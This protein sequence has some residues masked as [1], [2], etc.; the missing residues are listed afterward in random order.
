MFIEKN[1]IS[2]DEKLK[3]VVFDEIGEL[4]NYANEYYGEYLLDL[5][6]DFTE[7]MYQEDTLSSMMISHIISWGILC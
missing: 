6:N 4:Y 1:V 7:K 5:I 3:D 2:I